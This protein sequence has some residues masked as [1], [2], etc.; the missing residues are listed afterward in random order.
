MRT[1]NL[2][3][4]LP[5]IFG[6]FAGMNNEYADLIREHHKVY[7]DGTLT[8][9]AKFKHREQTKNQIKELKLSYV[10]KAKTVISKIREEYQEKPDAK[11]YTDMQKV[12]NAI[13]WTNIMPHA[14]AAEL[15][16][17]YIENKGDPDFMKLLKVEFK[18]RSGTADM[19]MQHLIHEVESGPDDGAFEMLDKIE[20]GLNS[21]V[22]MDVYPY[23]LTAGLAN[24]G[25]RQLNTDLDSFPIDGI[26][27][28]YRPVFSL[29]EK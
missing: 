10:N 22:S 26:G 11:Q 28:E 16:E 24:L 18:K 3:T 2:K 20:R 29:P 27:A 4:E 14:D 12:H 21:L 13:M 8:S 1:D 17:M 19:N 7:L 15:R 23:T 25:L 9:Q 5:R 6:V